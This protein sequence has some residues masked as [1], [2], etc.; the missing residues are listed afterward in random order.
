MQYN[1][2]EL[3]NHAKEKLEENRYIHTLGVQYTAASLAMVFNEDIYKAQTAGVLHDIAKCLPDD[4]I[5]KE[6]IENNISFSSM[7]RRNPY[8]L[9]GKLGAYYGKH[10]YQIQDVKILD[11]IT[12]HTTGRPDMG[13]LE[14][15]LFVADYIEP[16]RKQIP[17]LNEIRKV[18]FQNIDKAVYFILKN[19][20]AYLKSKNTEEIDQRT[21]EAFEFYKNQIEIM[22]ES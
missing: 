12:Y 8:L 6:C 19:T 17:G 1:L 14:K 18:S 15:I 10:V 2:L 20:L 11:A 21:I 3:Q 4:V 5:I 13:L 9:H 22:E 7:E 16:S